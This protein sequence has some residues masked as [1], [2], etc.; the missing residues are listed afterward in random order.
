MGLQSYTGYCECDAAVLCVWMEISVLLFLFFH[1]SFLHLTSR[2]GRQDKPSSRHSAQ[3]NQHNQSVSRLTSLPLHNNWSEWPQLGGWT[4]I[5]MCISC[6]F[7]LFKSDCQSWHTSWLGVS[8]AATSV[9]SLRFCTA[10]FATTKHLILY[11]SKT[12]VNKRTSRWKWFSNWKNFLSI[13]WSL[14]FSSLFSLQVIDK[15][16]KLW[17]NY[18]DGTDHWRHQHYS[19]CL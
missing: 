7:H 5:C 10:L 12:C 8:L 18:T 14:N 15:G 19:T 2:R 3:P 9:R 11:P 16:F 13:M 6:L 1:R 17:R 4:Q